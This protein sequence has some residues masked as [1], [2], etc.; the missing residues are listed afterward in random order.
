MYV[1]KKKAVELSVNVIIIAAI[2]LAVLVVLFAVFTGRLGAF[3]RGLAET[4][5]CEQ[6]CNSLDMSFIRAAGTSKTC[7]TINCELYIAGSYKNAPEGC[8]CSPRT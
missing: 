6:K 2:S 3:T 1:G 8:C 7:D 5:N 4:D